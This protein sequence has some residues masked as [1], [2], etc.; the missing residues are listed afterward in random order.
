MIDA[1][2]TDISKINEDVE[3]FVIAKHKIDNDMIESSKISKKM[4]IEEFINWFAKQVK[5]VFCINGRVVPFLAY[6][7]S[8]NCVVVILSTQDTKHSQSDASSLMEMLANIEYD[9]SNIKKMPTED[10]LSSDD[11]L[12]K[13]ILVGND[14]YVEK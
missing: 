7:T 10:M 4:T 14:V 12:D 1:V 11:E 2:F 5:M 9:I 6:H 8:S 13:Y 3:S